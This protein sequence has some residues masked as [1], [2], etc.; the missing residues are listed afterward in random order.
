MSRDNEV[1]FCAKRGKIT[2]NSLMKRI[3]RERTKRIDSVFET[4]SR[5]QSLNL[6]F[7]ASKYSQGFRKPSKKIRIIFFLFFLSD[8]SRRKKLQLERHLFPFL[9]F[10]FFFSSSSFFCFFFPPFLPWCS[11]VQLTYRRK[12]LSGTFS[13]E[14]NVFLSHPPLSSLSFSFLLSFFLCFSSILSFF[15][16]FSSSFSSRSASYSVSC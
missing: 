10:Q 12:E 1:S 3:R 9:S 2:S 11:C 8:E 14:R 15:S 7:V 13:R 4:R 16:P 5:E 6:L